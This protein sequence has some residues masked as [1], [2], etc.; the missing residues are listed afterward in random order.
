MAKTKNKKAFQG[1]TLIELLIVIAIIGILASIILVSLSSARQR[2]RVAEFKT[3]ATSARSA[4]AIDCDDGVFN[5]NATHIGGL[6]VANSLPSGLSFTTVPT[7]ANNP[8]LQTVNISGNCTVT[9]NSATNSFAW[10]ANCL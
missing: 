2:A 10:G 1:F 9:M 6:A 4:I 3:Q 5:G 7:C 8:V